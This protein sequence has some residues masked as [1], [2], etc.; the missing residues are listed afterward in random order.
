MHDITISMPCSVCPMCNA[1]Q[2]SELQVSSS[3][4]NVCWKLHSTNGKCH[5][6]V[7]RRFYGWNAHIRLDHVLSAVLL[8]TALAACR[9][10]SVMDSPCRL[11]DS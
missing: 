8:H 11:E 7:R 3:S 9:S 2:T 5:V 4:Q 6:V 10:I 1:T